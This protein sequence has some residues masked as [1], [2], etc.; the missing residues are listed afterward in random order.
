MNFDNEKNAWTRICPQ[1]NCV[2]EHKNK[3][4]CNYAIKKIIP[5]LR[6]AQKNRGVKKS[7]TDTCPICNEIFQISQKG[8]IIHTKLHNLTPEQLWL[9][10][11]N[12]E[13]TRCRCGCN[14]ITT[15]ID[16]KTGYREFL[17]GH[18][19]SIYTS[20][21]PEK[22]KD[23]SDRRRAKL[24]GKIGWSKGLTK[25]TDERIRLRG[26]ATSVGINKSIQENGSWI[27][28]KGLTKE[29]DSRV[30][31]YA[32]N[33]KDDFASGKC[34][35]WMVGKNKHNDERIAKMALKVSF[36]HKK[37][38]IRNYLDNLKRLSKDEIKSRVGINDQ[39]EIIDQ[40]FD[41][42]VS[43]TEHNISVRCKKCLIESKISI[44]KLSN[45]TRCS[46]C[47]PRGSVA[48]SEIY[49]FVKSIYEDAVLYN[50]RTGIAPLELDI[51]V[52]SRKFAIEYNGLYWHS[53]LQKSNDYHDNKSIL[54][55]K[56]GIT[57]FHIFEDEWRDKQEIVKSMIRHRLGVTTNK[58]NS[59]NCQQV[60]LTKSDKSKFFNSNHLEED[61]NSLIA[62]GLIDKN[63]EIVAALSLRK[64]FHKKY[65][66]ML[67]VVR[68]CTKLNTS[69]DKGFSKLI[70]MAYEYSLIHGYN[71]GLLSFVDTRIG[72]GV[73]L[74]AIGFKLIDKTATKFWWTDSNIRFNRFKFRASPKENLTERQIA[75]EVGVFKIWG[76]HNKI[77]I[78]NEE[79][80]DQRGIQ[81]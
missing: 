69:V 79:Y 25:E 68:F 62:F 60:I 61:I 35:P 8:L 14:G 7:Q 72:H 40:N 13:P 53:E 41:N 55:E 49:D 78:L 43:L 1:C 42:Y 58:I 5:C 6:C 74:K 30:A 28:N 65:Q 18:Q 56:Q 48:Q 33:K 26:I 4:K 24:I 45:G 70:K 71:N 73:S 31:L 57:L 54:C 47:Y 19:A 81:S 29:T 3:D 22:A 38:D 59:N 32:Q 9:K 20:Y 2:V 15:W 46:N 39:F 63:N 66:N 37:Q 77:Y 75:Q 27:W 50:D 52:P 12:T 23:I 16:W 44:T 17:I 34:V 11:H 76:C 80:R 21:S 64:V 51:F 36:T 10:K 67:E